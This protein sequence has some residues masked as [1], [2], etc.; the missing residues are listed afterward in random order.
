[1]TTLYIRHPAR[2]EQHAGGSVHFALA[3]DNGALVQQGTGALAAMG[4]L[5]AQAQRVV[6]LLAA[7]DV[8]LLKVKV[9]PL[10]NARL[11]A[12][13]ANLVE[14]QVLGDPAECVLV[15]APTSGEDGMRTVAVVQRLWLESL[16]KTLLGQGARTVAAL[17]AQ[18]C[19][20]IA[21]GGVSAAI[22]ASGA[23][24]ELTLRQSLN[25]GLGLAMEAEPAQ[26]L[27]TVRAL[28]GEAPVT[29]YLPQDQVEA[30]KALV[31]AGTTLEAEHWTHWVAGAKTT[32]LDLVS[33]LGAAGSQARNWQRWRWPLRVALL[34]V[35]VNIVALNV[36]YFQSKRE[37]AA[38]NLSI[39]Q[40][41]KAAYP[42]VPASTDALL[43]MQRNIAAAKA[44]GGEQSPDEF[45]YMASAF[46]E[47]LRAMPKKPEIAA[48]DYRERALSVRLK[49][50]SVD[51]GM[52]AQLK[53]ALSARHLTLAETGV[54]QWQLRS[55][56][57]KP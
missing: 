44:A 43:Q 29:L 48:L 37:A 13:L 8:S 49:P 41:F 24:H 9:P 53:D 50:E 25:D 21:A 38:V 32:M 52:V 18:L 1:M 6:L 33:G 39:N 56:G 40:A 36:Q 22:H 47:A 17:P 7:S 12:A 54:G 10:S 51:P 35:L 34:A 46:G 3:A 20:P 45:T 27:Q 42:K 5:V 4:D 19:L 23:M 2:A 16:V 11:K 26:L 31:D 14:E 55:G 57:G 28:A 30:Y 15:A